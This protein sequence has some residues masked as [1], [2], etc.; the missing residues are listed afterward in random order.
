MSNLVL[1]FF[2]ADHLSENFTYEWSATKEMEPFC[3]KCNKGR[4][5]GMKKDH[6]HRCKDCGNLT[7]AQCIHC[8]EVFSQFNKYHQHNCTHRT[9]SNKKW[10]WR[11]AIQQES[12]QLCDSHPLRLLLKSFLQH[13]ILDS[14][15]EG[16]LVL[17]QKTHQL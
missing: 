6:E 10:I 11:S 1:K 16:Y 14:K 13:F 2:D 17:L 7:K 9:L 15:L 5:D 12:P 8:G 3:L 4:S